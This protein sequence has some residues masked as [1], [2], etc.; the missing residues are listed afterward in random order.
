MCAI[1]DIS[2]M[3]MI[4]PSSSI[5]EPASRWV[6]PPELPRSLTDTIADWIIEQMMQGELRPGQNLNIDAL[7]RRFGISQT[8]IREALRT[9]QA[10]G[11]VEYR[12]RRSP[13]IVP[14]DHKTVTDLYAC[15]VYILSLTA[16][17][18]IDHMNDDHA[19]RFQSIVDQMKHTVAQQDVDAYFRLSIAFGDLLA[20]IAGNMVLGDIVTLLRRRS[21]LLRYLSLQ[22]A[23][24]LEAGPELSP[25]AV[26]RP[27]KKSIRAS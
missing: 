17:L 9:L 7:S 10:E 1:L 14:L 20:E 11:V 26:E 12:Y 4:Y 22:G 25:I 3:T 23:G 2:Y 8:P 13:R 24:R 15:R 21:L 18:T 16:R 19:S 5:Q 27:D 6:N